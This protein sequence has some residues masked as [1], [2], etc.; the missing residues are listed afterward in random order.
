MDAQVIIATVAAVTAIAS[1]WF[2]YRASMKAS[3]ISEMKVDQE[4]YDRAVGFYQKQLDDAGKQ[5]DRINLQMERLQTQ[6]DRV[7]TQ[8]DQ[9]KNTSSIL[10][11]QIT[12]LQSQVDTLN[13]RIIELRTQLDKPGGPEA[14][15][16]A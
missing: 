7:S 16:K 2:T 3:Q 9:E 5:V 11:S 13:G 6:L 15:G 8:L 1:A 10:R 4:A 14:V 12:N